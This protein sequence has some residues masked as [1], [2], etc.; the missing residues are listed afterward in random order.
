MVKNPTYW[1]EGKPY[2]DEVEVL[3]LDRDDDQPGA[4]LSG[5]VDG[6]S[7]LLEEQIQQLEGNDEVTLITT[8]NIYNPTWYMR[9]DS[10]AF[11]DV[12][13]RQAFKLAVDRR[14][15]R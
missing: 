10:D 2:L 9:L 15:M 5:Q 13:V 8:P 11:K 7:G 6:T 1:Q 3:N 4:I 12:R 14:A